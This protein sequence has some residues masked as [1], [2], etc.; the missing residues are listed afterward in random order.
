MAVSIFDSKLRIPNEYD[1]TEALGYS[2]RFWDEL[3]EYFARTYTPTTEE[4]KSYG[5]KSGWTLIL[6][7]EGR[8]IQYLYPSKGYFLALFVFGEQTVTAAEKS[9]LPQYVVNKIRDARPY[10]EG[11]SFNIEVRVAGDLEVVKKLIDI[12]IKN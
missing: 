10:V 11:R 9:D 5:E 8:T 6:K 4:W 3:R 7:Y 2:K 1:V 12:K